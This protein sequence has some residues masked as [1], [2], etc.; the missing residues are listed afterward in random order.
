MVVTMLALEI[1]LRAGEARYTAAAEA[2]R[3]PAQISQA[4]WQPLVGSLDLAARSI[5]ILGVG[6]IIVAGV[7]ALWPARL[8]AR[9]R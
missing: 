2:A 9:T 4:M 5:L 1:G 3:V 7:A 6:T 8:G